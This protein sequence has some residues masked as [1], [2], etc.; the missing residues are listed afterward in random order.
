M[1]KSINSKPTRFLILPFPIRWDLPVFCPVKSLYQP[2][3]SEYT[4]RKTGKFQL[5][6]PLSTFDAAHFTLWSLA[7][8]ELKEEPILPGFLLTPKVF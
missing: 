6:A 8:E 4:G 2:N 5:C 7:V 1:K 3:Q